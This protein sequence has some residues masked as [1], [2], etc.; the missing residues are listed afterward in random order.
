MHDFCH[1]SQPRRLVGI[2]P[3]PEILKERKRPVEW[4]ILIWHATND[5]IL[6]AIHDKIVFSSYLVICYTVWRKELWHQVS[7]TRFSFI[8]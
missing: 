7:L 2:T 5:Y 8:S 4:P 1:Q 3:S 6:Y